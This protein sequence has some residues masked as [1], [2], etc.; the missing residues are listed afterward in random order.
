MKRSIHLCHSSSD[1]CSVLRSGVVRDRDGRG[2]RTRRGGGLYTLYVQ[3]TNSVSQITVNK[4]V[5][6]DGIGPYSYI[7]T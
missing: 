6:L 4:V 3:T 2:T 5:G 1:G 7:S